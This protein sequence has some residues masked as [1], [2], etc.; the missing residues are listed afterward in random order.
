MQKVMEYFRDNTIALLS[1]LSVEQQIKFEDDE[2]KLDIPVG[3]EV[4]QEG[5]RLNSF[6]TSTV[7]S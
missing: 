7:R 6:T 4:V 2:I 5:W 3:G 1:R